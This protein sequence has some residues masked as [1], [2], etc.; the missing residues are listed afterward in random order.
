MFFE[1][2]TCQDQQRRF[3]KVAESSDGGV[4]WRSLGSILSSSGQDILRR[5]SVFT[6]NNEFLMVTDSH[7]GPKLLR[8]L[9]FPAIWHLNATLTTDPLRGVSIIKAPVPKGVKEE[10]W[11]MV[12]SLSTSFLSSMSPS[13]YLLG[14]RGANLRNINKGVENGKGVPI[15]DDVIAVYTAPSPFGPW[16][17]HTQSPF[18][19]HAASPGGG[20]AI[21]PKRA[22][23]SYHDN[24]TSEE[25]IIRLGRSCTG[26]PS[27]CGD[28][29]AS[30]FDFTEDTL[31]ESPF[32]LP[33]QQNFLGE[34]VWRQGNG[35]DGGERAEATVAALPS[36]QVAAIVLGKP[37]RR[38]IRPWYAFL[39][40]STVV[41]LNVAVMGCFG[42]LIAMVILKNR[43][44]SILKTRVFGNYYGAG[45]GGGGGGLN[46]KAGVNTTTSPNGI[47]NSITGGGGDS[48]GG[49]SYLLPD[50]ATPKTSL[51]IQRLQAEERGEIHHQPISP[52]GRAALISR[53]AARNGGAGEGS[54][55]TSAGAALAADLAARFA[56]FSSMPPSSSQAGNGQP[57]TSSASPTGHHL[58]LNMNSKNNHIHNAMASSLSNNNI[59]NFRRRRRHQFKLALRGAIQRSAMRLLEATPRQILSFLT[60]SLAISSVAFAAGRLHTLFSPFWAPASA[61]DVGG[62]YSRFTL[63]VMS[64]E[65]RRTLLEG[66]IR[67]YQNCPSVGEILIVWNQLNQNHR[68]QRGGKEKTAVPPDPL[69]DYPWA[70]VPIRVRA[71]ANNSLTNRYLPDDQLRY[72]GVLSL[73]DDLRL[74]CADVERAFAKWR[75]SPSSLTGY[76][77]RLAEVSTTPRYQSEPEAV[78][79]GWYNLILTGAAFIDS[80]KAFAAYW[81]DSKP[82]QKA[83]KLVDS[84]QNCDDILMN[85]VVANSTMPHDGKK[86]K[87]QGSVLFVRPSRRLDVSWLSGVGLSHSVDHFLGDAEQCL[88]KFEKLFKRWPLRAEEF[89]WGESEGQEG[90][91]GKPKCRKGRSHLDCSYLS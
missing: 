82:M 45:N 65:S 2:L 73:D 30:K 56:A 51:A 58:S 62:Q 29:I 37:T 80:R 85:F 76:V 36:G 34:R 4:T 68:D 78:A 8:C 42:S 63:L 12:G 3:I 15:E 79:K 11:L 40:K 25:M 87:K 83:R 89:N 23:N 60:V 13:S 10:K 41:L 6:Y 9:Q 7:Q 90:G 84:L 5:P 61:I 32:S 53:A 48:G 14:R 57:S 44:I 66:Y 72:R 26:G 59:N 71:H 86:G 18:R 35:W 39:L 49:A 47:H 46:R 50:G 70:K 19:V 28:V 77:A 31:R 54:T 20:L 69:R 74:P 33:P 67:N 22:F 21:L 27:T 43:G 24:S 91:G 64:Y 81:S 52:R 75:L 1:G 55:S 16:K 88:I 38:H 17:Q